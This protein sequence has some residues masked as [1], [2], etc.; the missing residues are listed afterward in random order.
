[1]LF[2]SQ[3]DHRARDVVLD[4]LHHLNAEVGTT[5]MIVTHDAEVASRL[6]RTVTI[7]DGRVGAEGRRGEEFAVVSADGALPLTPDALAAF[8]PGSLVRIHEQ[9]GRWVLLPVVEEEG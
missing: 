4:A 1:M 6:P 3:L 7:R 8:P 2:R 5:I 9:D